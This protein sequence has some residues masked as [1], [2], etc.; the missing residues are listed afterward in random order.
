MHQ[1]DYYK[2]L[3]V[4]LT[5]SA[6]E[7]KKSYRRLALQYHPDKNFGNKIYE[8]KFKEILDAYKVLS[9]NN[10]RLEYNTQRL[11]HSET[12]KTKQSG[13]TQTPTTA[14]S[15]L[16]QAIA[17]RKK[18]A[19]LDP[20]RMNKVALFK[21]IQLLLSKQNIYTIKLYN[22]PKL[23]K[24]MVE[25]ILYCSKFLTYAHVERICFQLTAL[26]G[27]DN[28]LYRRIYKF[29][30]EIRIKSIWEKYKLMVALLVVLIICILIFFLSSDGG[31]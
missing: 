1:K 27:T 13:S 6:A 26:A 25:E 19:V 22:D 15:L 8:A 17:F 5:A 18:I 16:N 4:N 29:S 23:N 2:I 9:D 20:Y 12:T 11:F 28:D 31:Y 30:K 21:Q 7:I 10:K 3:E 24:R 14:I